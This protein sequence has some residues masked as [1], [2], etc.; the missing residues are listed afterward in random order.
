MQVIWISE[1]LSKTERSMTLSSSEAELVA[2][3]EAMKKVMFLIQLPRSIKISV[4]LPVIVHVDNVG[5]TLMAS[6]VK[7]TSWTRH[8]G[9]S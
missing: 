6:S 4:K 9:I 8:V 3:S 5:A 7:T 2:L 1:K